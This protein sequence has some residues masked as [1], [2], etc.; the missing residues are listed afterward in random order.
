M[1]ARF[2]LFA[3]L[4]GALLA[5]G[6]AGAAPAAPSPTPSASAPSAD[7]VESSE[8]TTINW[9][10]GTLSAS[11]LGL[12]SHRGAIAFKRQLS[13]RAATADAY[14][15]LAAAIEG[16]RI[17][18]DTRFRDLAVGDPALASRLT[19]LVKHA[20][21]VETNTWP[22]HSAEVVL[23][24]PLRGSAGIEGLLAASPSPAPSGSG[25]PAPAESPAPSAKPSPAPKRG[26]LVIDARG[27][28]AQP[29]LSPALRD[30]EN[31]VIDL[32]GL[33]AAVRYVKGDAEGDPALADRPLKLKAQRVSGALRADLILDRAGTEALTAA[34]RARAFG[35]GAAFVILL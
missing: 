2:A 12:P 21:I 24:V 28:G 18:A 7:V 13:V 19:D 20:K 33:E 25:S 27:L 15:R 3:T 30:P 17:D 29:A 22:D 11:G 16:L 23:S 1:R 9:T 35:A 8:Q 31:R 14:R 32:A 6:F 26:A 34:V 10:S 4:L 5:P